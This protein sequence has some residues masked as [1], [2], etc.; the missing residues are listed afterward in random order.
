[1]ERIFE[2]KIIVKKWPKFELYAHLHIFIH[3]KEKRTA[4]AQ[5]KRMKQQKVSMFLAFNNF[6]RREIHKW[7]LGW[8]RSRNLLKIEM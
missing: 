3:V 4:K 7:A 1:M 5:R 2:R 6:L 8:A